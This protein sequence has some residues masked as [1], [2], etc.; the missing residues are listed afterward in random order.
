MSDTLLQDHFTRFIYPFAYRE[1]S[2]DRAVFQASELWEP[3]L[4]RSELEQ[5]MLPHVV[6][7]LCPTD[8]AIS[9]N[10]QY[11]QSY[12]LTR[13]GFD[14]LWQGRPVAFQTAYQGEELPGTRGVYTFYFSF[15]EIEIYLFR[16]GVGLLVFE[17]ELQQNRLDRRKK[18]GN[19]VTSETI[20]ERSEEDLTVEDLIQFNYALRYIQGPVAQ[21][22]E[23]VRIANSE[24]NLSRLSRAILN[25]E[26]AAEQNP[27]VLIPLADSYKEI[28]I[29]Y[30][31]L[32]DPQQAATHFNKAIEIYKTYQAKNGDGAPRLSSCADTSIRAA[33]ACEALGDLKQSL[34]HL[35]DAIQIYDE[36]LPHHKPWLMSACQHIARIHRALG[37][38]DQAKHFSARVKTE[39]R[40]EFSRHSPEG[41]LDLIQ[42]KE[43]RAPQL[44]LGSSDEHFPTYE[45]NDV[46]RYLLTSMDISEIPEGFQ[47]SY[48]TGYTFALTDKYSEAELMKDL[49]RLRRFYRDSYLPSADQLNYGEN[50]EIVR[51]FENIFFGLCLEGG[52]VQ[53]LKTEFLFSENFRHS[54]KY[55]YF[56]A[57]LI[58]LHQRNALRW[59]AQQ[60]GEAPE[61]LDGHQVDEEE[62]RRV[63]ILRGKI[64]NFI[65]R[66]RFN[67]ISSMTMHNRIYERWR[68]IL[69][70]E[71]LLQE[72][73]GE[74]D[75][76]DEL[77]RRSAAEEEAKR[78]N[79]MSYL[80]NIIA[81]F[82]LP[83][84]LLTSFFGMNTKEINETNNLSLG[85]PFPAIISG[86]IMA[87][88]AIFGLISLRR[89]K[90]FREK[91]TGS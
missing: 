67:Q 71:E 25:Q 12:R 6:D 17:V 78:L 79:R 69:R 37:E 1:D 58:A 20:Y 40:D 70:I 7:F 19:D 42:S 65:V 31:A 13:Q 86:G 2:F 85:D 60:V 63:R 9:S 21:L 55:R 90:G 73:K 22:Y 81:W 49:F 15:E 18:S 24:A 51:T 68:D 29:I 61:Y 23:P 75:E 32:D 80:L 56:P 14:R 39:K 66:C 8:Q 50:P 43:L 74:V 59:L 87:I 84:T 33:I 53:I 26:K 16:S 36:K 54:V 44:E 77:L 10:R 4:N 62:C 30:Q 27:Q 47:E 45:I 52:A 91:N 48:L 5:S 64:L 57:F 83:L 28:G 76:L 89:N 88:F 38:A 11:S 46:I 72:L 3:V 82:M 35:Q 34:C 41:L